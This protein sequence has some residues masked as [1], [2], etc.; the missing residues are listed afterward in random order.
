MATRKHIVTGSL[1]TLILIASGFGLG[2]IANKHLS[3][4]GVTS[5]PPAKP[6]TAVYQVSPPSQGRVNKVVS[7][8]FSVIEGGAY[9]VLPAQQAKD[10]KEGNSVLLYDKDNNV[11]PIIGK[12][13]SVVE[14]KDQSANSTGIN[15]TVEDS[16]KAPAKNVVRG[17]IVYETERYA[18]RLPVSALVY[19]NDESAHVWSIIKDGDG[20]HIARLK[21]LPRPPIILGDFFVMEGGEYFS[22]VYILDP[23]DKLQNDQPVNVTNILYEPA[24][25]P[26]AETIDGTRVGWVYKLEKEPDNSGCELASSC[27]GGNA[28]TNF[29][30]K[31]KAMASEEAKKPRPAP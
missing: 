31:I 10:I 4:S 28:V 2:L 24:P 12:V 21:A 22:D 9:V 29:I 7:V 11:L 8:T 27:G 15:I 5:P 18:S 19:H 3:S 13:V 30:D 6:N 20:G 1:F 16:P 14:G 25:V 23:D 17:D 26:S